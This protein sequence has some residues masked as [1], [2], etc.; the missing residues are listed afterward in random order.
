MLNARPLASIRTTR[1]IGGL[2]AKISQDEAVRDAGCGA[3]IPDVVGPVKAESSG[4]LS[5]LQAESEI[6]VSLSSEL[7]PSRIGSLGCGEL[8]WPEHEVAQGRRV[9]RTAGGKGED[10]PRGHSEPGS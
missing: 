10:R 4:Q 8:R 3:R 5:S 6:A 9:G 2:R 7:A 1:Y